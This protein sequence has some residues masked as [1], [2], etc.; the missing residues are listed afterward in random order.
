MSFIRKNAELI[1]QKLTALLSKTTLNVVKVDDSGVVLQEQIVGYEFYYPASEIQ[2]QTGLERCIQADVD[3]FLFAFRNGLHIYGIAM[4]FGIDEMG[5]NNQ[6]QIDFQG[7]D[8]DLEIYEYWSLDKGVDEKK[9]LS[10]IKTLTGFD[11]KMSQSRG[12]SGPRMMIHF[13]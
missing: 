6:L 1:A 11:P 7:I 12:I 8:H 9:L 4:S 5:Y 13:D 10:T 3:F 2:T